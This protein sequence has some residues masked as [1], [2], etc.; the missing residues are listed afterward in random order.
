MSLKRGTDAVNFT[1]LER[2]K[3]FPSPEELAREERRKEK[4]ARSWRRN[5]WDGSPFG[6]SPPWP[7][8]V[9]E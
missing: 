2:T 1:L 8:Y 9:T 4:Q 6:Y 5:D 7:E 3:Y